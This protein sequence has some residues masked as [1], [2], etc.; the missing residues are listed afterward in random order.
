MSDVNDLIHK[1]M[2]K[3]TNDL[4]SVNEKISNL[5]KII[6]NPSQCRSCHQP[7]WWVTT[8]FKK[9]MPLNNDITPH[10]A[11]CPDAQKWRKKRE[12]NK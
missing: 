7:I 8:K 5:L 2:P 6:A 11:S 12:A 10:F 9:A 3:A 1:A 4:I